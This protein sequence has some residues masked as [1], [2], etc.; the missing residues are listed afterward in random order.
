MPS[1][2]ASQYKQGEDVTELFEIRKNRLI[3]KLN[4]SGMSY[5]RDC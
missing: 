4:P 5:D 2:S 1:A 3:T